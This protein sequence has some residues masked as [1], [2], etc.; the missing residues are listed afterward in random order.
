MWG[1]QS[2]CMTKRICLR[3]RDHN[4][5]FS[6]SVVRP[7]PIVLPLQ[8]QRH[9]LKGIFFS[10]HS[11]SPVSLRLFLGGWWRGRF[12]QESWRLVL[13][14]LPCTAGDFISKRFHFSAI[15]CMQAQN[16]NFI[17]LAKDSSLA[18]AKSSVRTH[19]CEHCRNCPMSGTQT[20]R[21][22]A[23]H[24]HF[25]RKVLTDIYVQEQRKKYVQLIPRQLCNLLFSWRTAKTTMHVRSFFSVSFGTQTRA[26]LRR[27]FLQWWPF[28]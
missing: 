25:C 22:P 4:R 6:T 18:K 9:T 8:C 10:N 13:F 24:N 19:P 27:T 11:V 14:L 16:W 17:S 23:L 5:N 2:A 20:M 3:M 26:G 7:S 12:P 1:R 21:N 15:P 28:I